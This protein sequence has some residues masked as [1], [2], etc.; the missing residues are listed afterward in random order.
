[1]PKSQMLYCNKC[2]LHDKSG[3]WYAHLFPSEMQVRMCGDDPILKVLVTEDPNG[4]YFG[5]EYSDKDYGFTMI[6]PN[7]QLVDICFPYGVK[8][9]VKAGQG[10]IVK[11]TITEI[12]QGKS[13]TADT[14]KKGA[15]S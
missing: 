2:E 5:W 10:R 13:K 4:T 6:Y 1:M 7:M 14:K 12:P 8:A 9:A 11:L 15:K 3:Y